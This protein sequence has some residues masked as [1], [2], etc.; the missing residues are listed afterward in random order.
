MNLNYL[1]ECVRLL[2]WIYFKP[3]T[4]A[5]W[6]GKINPNLTSETNPFTMRAEFRVNPKL[7]RYAG[8]LWFLK[9]VV[10]SVAALL[11]GIICY[12]VAEPFYWANSSLCLMGWFLGNWV[13]RGGNSSWQKWFILIMSMVII[14]IITISLIIIG[15]LFVPELTRLIIQIISLQ[16]LLKSQFYLGRWVWHWVCHWV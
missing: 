11:V 14:V 9:V 4:L 8:Q 3:V 6:L 2:Y 10:P 13:A 12:L 16:S 1:A 5:E 7:R 15:M